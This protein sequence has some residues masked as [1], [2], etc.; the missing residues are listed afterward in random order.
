MRNLLLLIFMNRFWN[1]WIFAVEYYFLEDF[2]GLIALIELELVDLGVFEESLKL[3]PK[4]D[5][6]SKCFFECDLAA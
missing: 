1:N 2:K 6:R 4:E 5:L 3:L